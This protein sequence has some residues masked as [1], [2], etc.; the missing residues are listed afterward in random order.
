M[1]RPAEF[2]SSFQI[3]HKR[4]DIPVSKAV[5]LRQKIISKPE[6]Q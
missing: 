3:K 2:V 1:R 5:Y 4:P 6:L